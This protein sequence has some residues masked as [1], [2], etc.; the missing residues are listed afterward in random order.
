LGLSEEIVWLDFS[1]LWIPGENEKTWGAGTFG[2]E[3]ADEVGTNRSVGTNFNL[4]DANIR[5][6]HEEQAGGI[7]PDFWGPRLKLADG[8][9]GITDTNLDGCREKVIE[10]RGGSQEAQA[11][12]DEQPE[13][14][15][16]NKATGRCR[17][18]PGVADTGSES[19]GDPRLQ[20][21][22]HPGSGEEFLNQATV[23]D[24]LDRSSG[25]GV[26]GLVRVDTHLGI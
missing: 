20:N 23:V 5:G 13:D 22:D 9:Y 12:D 25:L 14:D 24:Q 21:V 7:G 3:K 6:W 19:G 18:S 17:A 26:Q 4:K 16:P 10:D 11:T 1:D 15:H 8:G 2:V